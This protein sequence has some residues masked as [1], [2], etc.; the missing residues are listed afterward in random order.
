MLKHLYLDLPEEKKVAEVLEFPLLECL[1]TYSGMLFFRDGPFFPPWIKVPITSIVI[2]DCITELPS[3]SSIWLKTKDM[4]SDLGSRA[5][6]LEELRIDFRES[7]SSKFFLPVRRAANSNSRNPVNPVVAL[8]DQRKKNVEELLVVEGV[9][10]IPLKR[11]GICF[12]SFSAKQID[13]MR[14]LVEEVFDLKSVSMVVEI[15]I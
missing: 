6:R 2:C 11:L 4:P 1:E 8:L 3:V 10:M 5:P 12:E 7:A 15:E 9:R 13:E 14:G